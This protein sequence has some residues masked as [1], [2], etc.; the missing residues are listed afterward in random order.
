MEARPEGAYSDGR[1]GWYLKATLGRDPVTG[2]HL[3]VTKRGF[4]TA[5]EAADA[6]ERLLAQSN[7]SSPVR[8]CF[9]GWSKPRWSANGHPSI[10][11]LAEAFVP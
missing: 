2:K 8:S 3:Q 11:G 1:G 4:R 5:A 7:R 6:R 10:R 9:D